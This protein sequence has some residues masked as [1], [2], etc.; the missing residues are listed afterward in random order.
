M[1]IF[2]NSFHTPKKYIF[3]IHALLFPILSCMQVELSPFDTTEQGGFLISA[4]VMDTTAPTFGGVSSAKAHDASYI[5]VRWSAGYDETW[6]TWEL[7]YAV[8]KSE[9]SGG[10]DLNAPILITDRGKTSAY[11]GG[12]EEALPYYFVVRAVDA[13]GNYDDNT[14]ELSGTPDGTA[15]EFAGITIA[16]SIQN[17]GIK[18]LWDAATDNVETAAQLTYD[19]YQAPSPG[20]QDLATP[21]FTTD[22]GA[23]FYYVEDQVE[24]DSQ[25]FVVRV[26]DTTG[27]QDENIAERSATPDG[28]APTNAAGNSFVGIESANPTTGGDVLLSWSTASDNISAAFQIYYEIYQAESSGAQNFDVPTYTT[29]GGATEYTVSGLTDDGTSYFFVVRASDASGNEESNTTELSAIPDGTEP[30]FDGI[31]ILN[32][33]T[34][35]ITLG[36]GP[37]TDNISDSANII[38]HIYQS[39]VSGVFDY[40]APVHTT[41]AGATGYTVTGLNASTMYYYVVRAQDEIGNVERNEMEL[42]GITNP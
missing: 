23:T 13:A 36:W 12:L 24:G 2:S 1:S 35:Q 27:N 29:S 20:A 14:V 8:Y 17:R 28:T 34:G 6:P 42:N 39:E 7:A 9:T 3:F 11:V 4:A 33:G 10:Q 18:L 21:T 19:I 41:T 40:T 22:P 26:S 5:L 15:P 30:T 32:P 25:F 38:Y 16:T 37:A 31:T